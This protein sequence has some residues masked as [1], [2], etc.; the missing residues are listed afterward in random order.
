MR[1][2]LNWL[3]DYIEIGPNTNVDQ[4]CHSLTLAGLE[5]EE[6]VDSK[7]FE[8]TVI[9]L[10]ITPNRSD[11]LSHLGVSREIAAILDLSPRS[12]MLSLKEMAG[13]I[14]EKVCVE[15]ENSEDCPR[16]ALR[17]LENIKVCESPDWLKKRLLACGLRPVNN[18]VDVTNYVMLAR[19]Q[20]LHAFDYDKLAKDGTRAKI[21]VRR[22]K[23]DERIVILDGKEL[24]LT[25]DELVIADADGPLALAGI[26][27]GEHSGVK[28]ETTTVLLEAA[29]FEPTLIRKTA[30]KDN[31]SSESSY[32]FERGIDPNGVVDALDYAARL[33]VEISEARACRELIDIYRKRIDPL[34][35]M[36]RPERA[37][38]VLGIAKADFDQDVLRRK[39]M[40]LGIE[41]VAKRGEAIYFRVPTFRADLT[42][43]IDLI[44]EAARM[45]GYDKVGDRNFS[46]SCQTY[47][48]IDEKSESIIG[49]LKNSLVARGFFET[50]N[51]GFIS[52]EKDALFFDD[53]NTSI[54][55]LNPL[56]DRYSVMRRSLLPGLLMN[57]EHNLRNQESSIKLFEIGTVFLAR[58]QNEYQPQ[59]DL[60]SGTLDQDS[61]SLEREKIAGLI[62]GFVDEESIQLRKEKFDFFS[63]KGVLSSCLRAINLDPSIISDDL[64]FEHDAK[65]TGFH[66][67]ESCVV[68]IGDES[69]GRFGRLHPQVASQM[70]ISEPVFIFEFDIEKLMAR[71]PNWQSFKPF[72]RYP[73]VSRDVALVV[74]EGLSFGKLAS[75]VK[76]MKKESEFLVDLEIFD[77]YQGSNIG[78]G[79]KSLAFALTFQHPERTMRD[80]EADSFIAKLVANAK[81][82]FG[83]ILRA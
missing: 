63:L 6:V 15:I 30:K 62:C 17:V 79:K 18:V 21:F 54:K 13:P 5:V 1:I 34:E 59:P 77:I 32:R 65:H 14:H 16:Y 28:S 25:K 67:G 26:M 74:D 75:I 50:V 48:F 42:R 36:M 39:F 37:Q 78:S 29:Y 64:T 82:K 3:K 49:K 61:Y 8:D 47:Y 58:R 22:A 24:S 73:S 10:G 71:C 27:G 35:V 46:D 19:G 38:A 12:P 60:L 81:E 44:E 72:S 43:E 45:I 55:I 11:A 57:L 33:L 9:T 66:P 83:A 68:K 53:E 4:L 52:K 20:P 80:E 70:D 7:E 31:L 51:L 23:E 2:C 40:R 41:T 76:D 69:I 56:S